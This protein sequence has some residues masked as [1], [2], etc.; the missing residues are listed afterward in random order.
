VLELRLDPNAN[1]PLFRPVDADDFR[2]NGD[3]ASDFSNLVENGL[4]R[5]RIARRRGRKSSASR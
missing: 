3:A 1:D 4:I 2:V 5:V